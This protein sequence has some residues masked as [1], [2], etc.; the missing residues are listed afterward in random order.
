MPGPGSF[1][2]LPGFAGEAQQ[3][4]GQLAGVL[5]HDIPVSALSL[6]NAAAGYG[7]DL[8]NPG[9][10]IP[11]NKE[12]LDRYAESREALP[13]APPVDS[14]FLASALDRYGGMAAQLAEEN[15]AIYAAVAAVAKDKGVQSAA[16][17]SDLLGGRSKRKVTEEVLEKADELIAA[18]RAEGLA[19]YDKEVTFIEADVVDPNVKDRVGTT[20]QYR[21]GPQGMDSPQRLGKMRTELGRLLDKGAEGR[22]WY[23][24]SAKTAGDLTSGPRNKHL[25]AGSTAITSRGAAVPSNQVFG[26]KGYNQVQAGQPVNTGR[27]P[28]AQ[29][30]SIEQ[31]ASGQPYIGGPKETPF[32]EGLTVDERA[33]GIRP[34]NDLW[35]ARAFG[36]QKPNA[37]TGKMEEWSEGL[38]L[39]Q[40]RFMDR[41]INRLTKQANKHKIGGADDWTPERVQAAIWVAKK[42]ELE[43]T[44]VA[45][46]SDD[47]SHNLDKLTSNVRY[48]S[49]PST[50]LDHL[51]GIDPRQHQELV[52][53]LIQ[54]PDGRDRLA[55]ESGMLTR[56]SV[57]G[58]GSYEGVVSPS[59]SARVMA[60]PVTGGSQ[61]DPGSQALVT[62]LAGGR[63]MTLGQDTVGTTY[64][65][66]PKKASERSAATVRLGETPSADEM[67]MIQKSLDDKFGGDVFALHT[68]NGIE[69]INPEFEPGVFAVPDKEFTKG[70]KEFT[71][72]NQ[73]W[74]ANSGGLVGNVDWDNPGYKPSA[75]MRDIDEAGLG[76][77]AMARVESAVVGEADALNRLDAVLEQMPDVG[78]RDVILTKTREILQSGGFDGIRKAVEAG[79][80]PAIVLTAIGAGTTEGSSPQPG[81]P[82]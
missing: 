46:A 14:D 10:P 23:D 33:A 11:G 48:E 60:A 81:G 72:G 31:L 13:G 6:G 75:Y 2:R 28:T 19:D 24:Q 7:L 56:E 22:L 3:G 45:R 73:E 37:K 40:H 70:V 41:E 61:M 52:D 55:M 49:R 39:A 69:I 65:R 8:L 21:G 16:V 44:S 58:S 26:V 42:A 34:T 74:M 53:Q 35:M 17:L 77:E 1:V 82:S 32:Y 67:R 71:E 63:G 62:A 47:F 5:A 27:F 79:I 59:T 20:G 43:G 54:T 66:T 57:P 12:F 9:T 4:L 68:E 25:Y 76:P 18:R 30:Q 38:G 64:L 15:P 51:E 29:G 78:A 50:S 80:L 36:Y